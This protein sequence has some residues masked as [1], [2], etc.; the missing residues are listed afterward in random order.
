MT[1][2]ARAYLPGVAST[3]RVPLAPGGRAKRTAVV[4]KARR[5]ALPSR[6]DSMGVVKSSGKRMIVS[7]CSRWPSLRAA[8]I[9]RPPGTVARCSNPYS[10]IDTVT[11]G[12]GGGRGAFGVAADRHEAIAKV[13]GTSAASERGPTRRPAGREWRPDGTPLDKRH[14]VGIRGGIGRNGV[15]TASRDQPRSRRQQGGTA[16]QRSDHPRNGGTRIWSGA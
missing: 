3:E 5:G 10:F 14:I 15:A 1:K 12:T 13:K 7:S 16:S 2:H 8:N 9:T 11:T 6:I 4:A